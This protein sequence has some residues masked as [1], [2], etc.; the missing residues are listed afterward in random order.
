MDATTDDEWVCGRVAHIDREAITV[1]VDATH[2][3]R[4]DAPAPGSVR[5][6]SVRVERTVRGELEVHIGDLVR[7]RLQPR[8]VGEV[9][10]R[11]GERV[12]RAATWELVHRTARASWSRGSESQRFQSAGVA[13]RLWQRA[14]IVAE[15]R[16]HFRRR[17]FLE[18]ETPAL[19]TCPGLDV[20]LSAFAVH[21][22]VARG[23]ARDADQSGRRSSI[24]PGALDPI[25][26]LAT[27]PE[28][29]MKRALVG[30]I[31]RCFQLARCFR[32]DE[33]GSRHEREFTMLEWYRAWDGLDALLADTADVMR[34]AS[35]WGNPAGSLRHRQ[36][37]AT[38]PDGPFPRITVREAFARFAP[39]VG[40]PVSL[41]ARDETAYFAAFTDRI[42]PNLG[43]EF[44]TFLTHF[45][46]SLASL[47]ALDP[48][49][50]SVCLRFELYALGIEL[51]NGFVELTDPDEHR[52]RFERDQSD[53][54][55]RG[56][57]VYPIDD[58]FL[59]ALDEGLPPSVGNALG[60]DRLVALALGTDSIA[61]VLAFPAR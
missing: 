5:P 14:E 51:S 18:I 30:G 2:I 46:A 44:P 43:T 17:G 38:V 52:E 9:S 36:A 3:V 16:D 56:L 45:P 20:H 57:A 8:V 58:A 55:G 10:G 15:I 31:R 39:G 54:A 22:P 48:E 47:A 61:E 33:S 42:E 49:D 27:S 19:V 6:G 4:V 50:A 29:A 1:A 11:E 12:R 21:A 32:A 7:V 25:A 53:R 59:S 13:G 37:R 26:W 41:A 35:R 23:T 24:P 28:F 60:I 34:I 40:D